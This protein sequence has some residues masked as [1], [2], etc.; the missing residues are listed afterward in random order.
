MKLKCACNYFVEVSKP[1]YKKMASNNG[2]Q[3]KLKILLYNN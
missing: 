3:I 1:G 2:C